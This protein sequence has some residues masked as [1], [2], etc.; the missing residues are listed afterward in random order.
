MS[1]PGCRTSDLSGLNDIA[2]RLIKQSIFTV[3]FGISNLCGDNT[4]DTGPPRNKKIPKKLR[5][6]GFFRNWQKNRTAVTKKQNL[7]ESTPEALKYTSSGSASVAANAMQHLHILN[8]SPYIAPPANFAKT[9][10]THL[11]FTGGRDLRKFT[12]KNMLKLI[13]DTV[14][15]GVNWGGANDKKGFSFLEVANIIKNAVHSQF[16]K[17]KCNL[18]DIELVIK[19]WLKPA[20]QRI[21]IKRKTR[22]A[23]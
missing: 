6:Q 2:C 12:N 9:K 18:S 20:P 8:T 21:K 15:A 10:A 3:L 4:T 23:I 13:I 16:S 14:A 17:Q 5:K 1:H 7:R 11:D 19:D 22:H